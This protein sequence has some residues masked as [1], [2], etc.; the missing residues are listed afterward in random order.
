MSPDWWEGLATVISKMVCC[1]SLFSSWYSFSA[2]PKICKMF[3]MLL[4]WRSIIQIFS[5]HLSWFET[6]TQFVPLWEL[7]SPALDYS[8]LK[9]KKHQCDYH[10]PAWD[11]KTFSWAFAASQNS[12][13]LYAPRP[14]CHHSSLKETKSNL[15]MVASMWPLH[16]SPAFTLK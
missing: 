5:F 12:P 2:S 8:C 14:G 11:R 10:S 4:K 15:W 16:G 1:V 7:K 3:S 13:T 9:K 6:Q